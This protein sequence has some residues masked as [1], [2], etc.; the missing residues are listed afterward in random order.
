MHGISV[1][2]LSVVRFYSM[3]NWAFL[4][5]LQFI[6]GAGTTDNSNGKGFNG[7]SAL[8]VNVKQCFLSADLMSR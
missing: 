4:L 7:C 8:Y 1:S 5:F 6:M 2:R 3:A